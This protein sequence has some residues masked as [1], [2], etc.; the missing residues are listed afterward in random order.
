MAKTR[1]EELLDELI[2]E[3]ENPE[4]LISEN[5]LLKELTKGLVEL[6]MQQELTTREIQ[7]H[8]QEIYRF[9]LPDHP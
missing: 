6:A 1:E 4:D 8:L 7:A 5:G 3:Y 2:E 9:N